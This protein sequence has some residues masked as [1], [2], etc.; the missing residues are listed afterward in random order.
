M[1]NIGYYHPQIVHFVVALL[2]A[3]VIARVVSLLPLGKLGER[4]RFTGPMAA[5]LIIV[6]A[7][8]SVL[9][10]QS[11]TDAHPPVERIPGARAAVQD[12]EDAGE[13]ARD[14]ALIV[15]ALEIG[16]LVLSTKPVGKWARVGS[17]VV[18]VVGLAAVFRAAQ[19]G[20]DLVYRYGGGVG[21]RSRDTT[22]VTRLLVAGLFNTIQQDRAAGHGADA[23][24]LVDELARRMPGDTSVRFM[25]LESRIRDRNDAAGALLALDSIAPGDNRRLRLQKALMTS[26]ALEALGRRDSA[27]TVL[28][29]LRGDFG[30]SRAYQQAMERLNAIQAPR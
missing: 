9:A 8:A 28:E 5:T 15:A 21:I 12:H 6:G 4:L 7:A 27:R 24:R 26:E 20:G 23:A 17:A 14:I 1:P 29:A 30:Q 16:A 18:G 22:D 3:G 25:V 19:K 10:A 2:Y 11:G 13:W